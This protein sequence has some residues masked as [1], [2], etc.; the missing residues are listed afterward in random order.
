MGYNTISTLVDSIGHRWHKKIV[1]CVATHFHADRTAGLDFLKNKGVKTYS[2]K[3]TYD[4]CKQHNEPQA[5]YYFLHDTT[6]NLGGYSFKTFYPGEGHSPDN[7]VIWFGGYKIL[8]AGC[9]VKSMANTSIGNLSDA[10]INEWPQTIKK[11]MK[12]FPNAEY[13]IPGHMAWTG[14]KQLQHTLKLIRVY[15]KAK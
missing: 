14:K 15:K 6:F 4:L 10:N 5:R 1:L 12:E 8:Y 2:S 11:V 9:L 3:L 7:I 13:V